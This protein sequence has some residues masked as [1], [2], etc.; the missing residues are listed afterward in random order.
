MHAL[1]TTPALD[2][3]SNISV[4][5]LVYIS[6]FPVRTLF[7]SGASH[8]C[9]SS[10][11]VENLHLSTSLVE[12]PVIV[13]NPIGGSAHLSMMCVDLRISILSVEFM[14]NAYVLG[15]MGY[16]L[17]LGMDWLSDYG[18]ILDCG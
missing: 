8:T 14:C 9:I 15:F 17:I 4:E 10:D 6:E 5:S 18:A 2:R 13:S 1:N 7:D 3:G 16:G 11:I 12:D